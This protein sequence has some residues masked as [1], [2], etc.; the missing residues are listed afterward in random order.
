MRRTSAPD[1]V[2]PIL[3]SQQRDSAAAQSRRQPASSSSAPAPRFHADDQVLGSDAGPKSFQR[4]AN[5]SGHAARFRH[6]GEI[7]GR[8]LEL[9]DVYRARGAID[10]TVVADMDDPPI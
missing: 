5:A 1:G 6:P 7:D 2:G 8:A 4:L 3:P 10:R 9:R